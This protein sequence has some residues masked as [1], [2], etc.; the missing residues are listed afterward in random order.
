MKTYSI[1]NIVTVKSEET[2]YDS[3]HMVLANPKGIALEGA[4]PF[5]RKLVLKSISDTGVD[6][7]VLTN[8]EFIKLVHTSTFTGEVT[9]KTRGDEFT[10]REGTMVR[11]DFDDPNSAWVP[12]IP[13]EKYKVNSDG[14][15]VDYAKDT[16][17][18]FDEVLVDAICSRQEE[19]ARAT[20]LAVAV[21][22]ATAE[23]VPVVQ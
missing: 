11:E 17:F 6:V 1:K 23:Q 5:T 16:Y 9:S 18:T 14:Q 4:V 2:D 20:R 12:A 10:A 19:E 8:R 7:D 3:L 21:A 22:K 15:Y 13:G